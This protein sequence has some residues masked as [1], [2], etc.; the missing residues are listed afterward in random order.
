M[1]S[2]FRIW[3][4]FSKISN[5]SKVI[6]KSLKIMT[7]DQKSFFIDNLFKNN[8]H[9]SKICANDR[10]QWEDVSKLWNFSKISN[11]S[12]KTEFFIFQIPA[13]FGHKIGHSSYKWPKSEVLVFTFLSLPPPPGKCRPKNLGLCIFRSWRI[14]KANLELLK[15]KTWKVMSI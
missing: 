11:I 4:P 8:F 9:M 7:F 2:A 12:R 1:I 3:Y 15:P 13:K 5:I 14:Q 6:D 10:S